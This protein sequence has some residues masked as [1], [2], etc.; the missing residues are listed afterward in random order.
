MKYTR[1]K[2]GEGDFDQFNA[3]SLHE[4]LVT[5]L[6]EQGEPDRWH[7]NTSDHRI[8]I[9]VHD[10]TLD[11]SGVDA[12]CQAHFLVDWKKVN[13]EKEKAEEVIVKYD[14][15]LAIQAAKADG[16]LPPDFPDE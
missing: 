12:V 16:K 11:T 8:H 6:G 2:D 7:L 13:K 10:N 15:K 4:E 3:S 5:V 14:R 1:I 9:I